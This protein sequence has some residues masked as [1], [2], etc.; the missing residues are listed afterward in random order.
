MIADWIM[1]QL[2]KVPD[3]IGVYLFKDA[4][5]R[6]L[7]IGKAR[8]LKKRMSSYF[9]KVHVESPKIQVMVDKV[10]DFDFFV[11]DN[12]VEALILE[13]NL[14]KRHRPPYNTDLRDDK[15]YPYL[16]IT[17]EDE[18]PRAYVTRELHR[19]G[20]RYFGPYTKVYALRKTLD[21]LRSI[22]PIRTYTKTRPKRPAPSPY[23]DYHVKWGFA[24]GSAAIDREIYRR[25]IDRVIDFLEGRDT[26][27]IDDLEKEMKKAADNLDFERAARLRDRIEATRHV[28]E[29]QKVVSVNRKD[30]DVIGIVEEEDEVYARV[31]FIRG[32]RLIGSRGYTLERG[33]VEGDALTSF[34][35]LFYA[36]A[37][38]IPSEILLPKAV[39][40]KN[41][42]ESWLMERRGGKMRLVVPLR[43]EKKDLVEMAM[44]NAKYSY[45]LYKIKGKEKTRQA[46][47]LLAELKRDLNLPSIPHRIEC[48]DISTLR[49]HE[50][51]GSM[52]VF[53]DGEPRRSDYR[54]F[55][56]RW[57]EGQD[58]FASMVEVLKR[59]LH[60][61]TLPIPEE[62]FAARPDLLVVDG[63][64]PQLSAA[65][66]ALED[67]G[68]KEIPVIALAKREEEIYVPGRPEPMALPMDSPALNLIRHLRDEA[69]R[70]AI[71]YH[72]GLREKAMIASVFDEIP[73]VGEARKKLLLRHFGSPDAISRATID[74][75]KAV[76]GLSNK[77]AEIIY[78][79]LHSK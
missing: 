16:A 69:H 28:L 43:G 49:G 72:R 47:W 5:G 73:G 56:I 12:E 8:S 38:A 2:K 67:L 36:E 50:T 52:V 13:N 46:A 24:P 45:E 53:A 7:Y 44:T 23:L 71:G 66:K 6:V 34:V 58:D 75:I 60:H 21:T 51:V 55:R 15:S 62:R 65:L 26:S 41:L 17:Y 33:Q 64:K 59:R 31:L 10:A 18:F 68:I 35:K 14:I 9:H 70:F 32:G 1:E 30:R 19:K 48:F 4:E 57:V 63:G 11:T 79:H 40:E 54:K 27:I 29:G 20:T 78:K 77:L 37:E 42:I 22:F 25:V 39:G 61:L 76:P 3:K 74:Q